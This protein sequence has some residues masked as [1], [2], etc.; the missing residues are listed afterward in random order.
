MEK[1]Y[2]CV[3]FIRKHTSKPNFTT[4]INF[5]L[6]TKLSPIV[7]V[8]SQL[9]YACIHNCKSKSQPTSQVPKH[10]KVFTRR[11]THNKFEKTL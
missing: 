4:Y 5:E 10:H 7:N 8:I 11:K 1:S 3:L 6:I 2:F 9:T